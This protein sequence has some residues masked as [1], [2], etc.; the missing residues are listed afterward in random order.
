MSLIRDG[1]AASPGI[2]IGPAVPLHWDPPR[3]P[4]VTVPEDEIRTAKVDLTMVG[5]QVKYQRQTQVTR[6]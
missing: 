1:I 5:G 6:R 4:H 3:A 2:V